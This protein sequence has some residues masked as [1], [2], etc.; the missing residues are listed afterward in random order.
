VSAGVTASSEAG[1]LR[2]ALALPSAGGLLAGLARLGLLIDGELDRISAARGIAYADYL[3]LATVRR[4]A[5]GLGRPTEMSAL[6]GRSTGGMT[7]TLDRLEAAGWVRREPDGRD[8]RRIQVVLTAP[9]RTLAETV[10]ADLHEWEQG[11]PL[12]TDQ[13]AV[14]GQALELLADAVEDVP[15]SAG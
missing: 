5:G 9:G 6:L 11:L 15:V 12:D 3:V 7:L 13:R 10:N 4:S 8:R 2:D 14:A 1:R